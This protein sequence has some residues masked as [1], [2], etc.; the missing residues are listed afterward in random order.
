MAFFIFL[1]FL[2]FVTFFYFNYYFE[3]LIFALK[4]FYVQIFFLLHW[5]EELFANEQVQI[6]EFLW[7]ILLF[8]WFLWET[9]HSLDFDCKLQVFVAEAFLRSD[10]FLVHQ[11]AIFDGINQFFLHS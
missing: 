9:A 4:G 10:I 2:E 1:D 8:L 3:D 7:V 5:T 11:R 6:L